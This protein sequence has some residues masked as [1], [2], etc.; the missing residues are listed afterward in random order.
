M[1]RTAI[2]SPYYNYPTGLARTLGSLAHER[3]DFTVYLVDDG[4]T[5]ALEITGTYPFP[6]RIVQLE[7]NSGI[8]AAL[9]AG[10]K[11]ILSGNFDFIARI[12]AG[13]NWITGRL[14]AQRHPVAAS[15]VR[16]WQRTL[17]L[18]QSGIGFRHPTVYA[19]EQ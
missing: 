3:E 2:L 14:A 16:H 10:L 19:F 18:G 13:D 15:A 17:H 5:P 11:E 6:I 9:N 1:T 8:V 4:N 7:K 12:D